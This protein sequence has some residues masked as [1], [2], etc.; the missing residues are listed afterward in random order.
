MESE[1][2]TKTRKCF[3]SDTADFSAQKK[4][5]FRPSVSATFIPT[6]FALM[7]LVLH[8]VNDGVFI[9]KKFWEEWLIALRKSQWRKYG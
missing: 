9:E 1:R 2:G 6:T 7:T 4:L 8:N 5:Q 3:W